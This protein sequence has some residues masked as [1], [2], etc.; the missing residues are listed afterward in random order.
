[1][2]F[3]SNTDD[4]RCLPELEKYYTIIGQASGSDFD[5]CKVSALELAWWK[6]RHQDI[7]PED[8]ARI[9]AQ[10]AS[11]YYGVSEASV[12]PGCVLRAEAM[13]YRDTRPDG[14]VTEPDWQEIARQLDLAYTG[15]KAAIVRGQ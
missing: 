5:V 3:R 15:V 4:P 2:F 10:Q 9:I 12:L 11:L 1:M 6:A 7:G 13:D 8:Y 14:K